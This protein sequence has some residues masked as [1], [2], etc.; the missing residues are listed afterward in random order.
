LAKVED[1]LDSLKAI[2][3]TKYEAKH[4]LKVH[5][6]EESSDESFLTL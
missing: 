2:S 6:P 1:D 4:F 5:F 3:E